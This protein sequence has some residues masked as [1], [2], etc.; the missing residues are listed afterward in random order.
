MTERASAEARLRESEERLQL[1]L[2]ASRGVGIWDWDVATDLVRADDRFARLYGVDPATA[3]D[4]GPLEIFFRQIHGDDIERVKAEIHQAMRS[5]DRFAS[6]YRLIDAQGNTR[7]VNAQGRCLYDDEGQPTR[8]PGVSFDVTERR[9]AEEAARRAAADLAGAT[10]DQAFVYDLAERQRSLDTP[11]AIMRLST[12]ALAERLAVDRVG[13]Y[14]VAPDGSMQFGPS[15]VTGGLPALH[16]AL[17]L[18]DLGPAVDSY[19]AGRTVVVRDS[20]DDPAYSD[21]TLARVSPAAVGVP[22]MRGGPWVATLYAN[23]ATARDW[24]ATEIALIEAVAQATW[25]AV[26]R[27]SAVTAL[28]ESEEKFRAIANSIDPMVWS[29]RPDGFH[30]YY[31]D[32]WYEYTGM[33]YGSTDG[34]AWNDVFHPE[35]QDRAWARWRHSLE[36]GDPYHIEYRLRHHSGVYRWVLGRAQA[37]RDDTG[38]ITRW[39]G[40]CTDIQDIVDAREVL[41]RSR[42]ELEHAIEE[43]SRQLMAAEERLRQAQKMEAI[44][45]LTGGI[46][47]DFNNMLAVVVGALDILE[48]RLAQGSTDLDRYIIAA[49]DGATRAAALTQRLL[50]FARQQP[51]A[52]VALD[53]NA[54]AGGMIDLLIRTLGEEVTVE[55][56]FAGNLHTALADPNLL[57]NVILNLSVNARDAMPRGGLLTIETENRSLEAKEAESLGL[58]PGDYVALSVTDTG[59]GM[60]AEVAARAFDP[61]FTTKGVGKGTGL[62]LSQV[63][64]FARQSGGHVA[65][66]SEPG[67]GTRVQ[68]LLPRHNREITPRPLDAPATI[69]GGSPDEVIL[70][71]EDEE[72]VRHYSVEAL[73]ELG[74]SVIQ[75]PDGIEA[76]R[77]IERGRPLSL[78]FTDVVMPDMTGDELA[79]RA[80]LHQPGLRVLYTSGYTPD[81]SAIAKRIADDGA[82]L[83]KPFGVNALATRVR[84]VLDA[85]AR[86]L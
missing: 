73:R 59:S 56:R 64:G 33:P 38:S 86:P 72:R 31:N 24:T 58:P 25:D 57:E 81:D 18:D 83:A 21:T 16:G 10:A 50:G 2:D 55:T 30:D 43:R 44:G 19:R 23:H 51:L 49:R 70:V 66:D 9:G 60:S 1:A 63:F 36:S 41:A 8:F 20:N 3:R 17:A 54:L 37:V 32:R 14:R 52:P 75:A 45:Q 74:Y 11:E 5:G 40:T 84:A 26:E 42:E 69:S 80:R 39:F 68:L 48:R 46:A 79:R 6:E 67:R 76:L 65:I 35:D 27:A 61:F 13:F 7:W 29:T 34:H 47:H 22:L 77:I 53:I 78:L 85:D 62:G 4:G 28:S 15:V 12:G 71:V 82:L